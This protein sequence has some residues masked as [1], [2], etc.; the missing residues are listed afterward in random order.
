MTRDRLRGISDSLDVRVEGLITKLERRKREV[1]EYRNSIISVIS[2]FSSAFLS[3]FLAFAIDQPAKRYWFF[4][5][6]FVS[7]IY[8]HW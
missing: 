6:F 4:L 8:L 5:F 7:G 3:V 2:V 1:I